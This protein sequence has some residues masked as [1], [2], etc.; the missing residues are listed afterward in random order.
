LSIPKT[1]CIVTAT[2]TINPSENISKIKNA[3][4]NIL[5][6]AQIEITNDIVTAT[7]N[8]DSLSKIHEVISSRNTQKAYRRHLNRNLMDD[9]TWFYLNKQAAFS[10]V[11][12][13]CDEADES[14]LGPI[15][16]I[17]KSKN[18]EKIIEWLV[19]D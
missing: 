17:L 5:L 13:L 11:I 6:D 9:S 4:L 16:I 14:P 2:T 7:T 18:I 15:K 19:F 1:A 12:A 10:N 3:I 8:I